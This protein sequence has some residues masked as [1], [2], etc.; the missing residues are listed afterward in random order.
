MNV[1]GQPYRT[2]WLD[3]DRASVCV[4]D[5]TLLPHRFEDARW[6][7]AQAAAAGIRT[8]VVR[9]APLI[10]AAAAYGIALAMPEDSSDENL[11]LAYDTL[12]RTRPTAV[13]LRWSRHFVGLTLP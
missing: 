12:S 11:Q 5:Q 9:G 10:G 4:I 7:S 6:R 2:I 1:D 13:H 3:D 8:M